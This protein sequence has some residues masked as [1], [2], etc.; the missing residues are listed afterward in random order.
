MPSP[1]SI[2]VIFLSF[3]GV[4]FFPW[5][6]GTLAS[7]ATLPLL[8]FLTKLSV[9]SPLLIPILILLIVGS[10]L[11]AQI[12]QKRHGLHDPQWIVI[13]EVIGM[14]VGFI[15]CPGPYWWSLIALF[16]L[17]RFFDI[18]KIWP[19]NVCDQKIKHGIGTILDD[20]VAGIYAGVANFFIHFAFSS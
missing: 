5:A 17:F 13:D 10:G 12:V 14:L 6:P 9:P 16:L 3:L 4:G 7:L 2:E 8:Y 1:Y 19:A 18:T 15:L 11:V 20:V